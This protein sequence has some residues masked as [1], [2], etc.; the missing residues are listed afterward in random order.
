MARAALA[1]TPEDDAI[2]AIRRRFVDGLEERLAE[3]EALFDLLDT[4]QD[5]AR[6]WAEIR[7]RVHRIAGIAGS[8]GFVA[9]GARAAQVDTAIGAMLELD[10][11]GDDTTLREALDS[12]LDDIDEILE[13]EAAA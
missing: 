2:I 6:V 7:L 10:V 8:L 12:L 13:A 4:G 11:P 9:L 3:L 1:L 5:F